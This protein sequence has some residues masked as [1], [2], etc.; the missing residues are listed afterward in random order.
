MLLFVSPASRHRAD[1]CAAWKLV[2]T[3]MET[4]EDDPPHF[5]SENPTTPPDQERG[6][7]ADI[8]SGSST[9]FFIFYYFLS[10]L[11]TGKYFNLTGESLQGE[12]ELQSCF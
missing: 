5:P 1:T 6:E 12:S 3:D 2:Y 9:F 10:P 7:A 4:S 11:L 8:M